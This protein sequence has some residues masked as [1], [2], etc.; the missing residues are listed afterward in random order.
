MRRLVLE[1]AAH[2]R[3]DGAVRPVS[4]SG[5]GSGIEEVFLTNVRWGVQSVELLEGRTLK[6]QAIRARLRLDR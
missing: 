2:G 4:M 6:C 3:H 1:A 5:T